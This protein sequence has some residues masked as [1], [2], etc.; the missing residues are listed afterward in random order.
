MLGKVARS[1]SRVV[2]RFVELVWLNMTAAEEASYGR[3]EA[4]T[5]ITVSDGEGRPE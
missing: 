2:A 4:Q 3:F 1:G 5:T